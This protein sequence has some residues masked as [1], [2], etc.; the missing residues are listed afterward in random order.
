MFPLNLFSISKFLFETFVVIKHI[1]K[2]SYFSDRPYLINYGPDLPFQ[3]KN[4][5]SLE[6]LFYTCLNNHLSFFF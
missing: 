3:G 5:D 1:R 2:L 6:F 4:L